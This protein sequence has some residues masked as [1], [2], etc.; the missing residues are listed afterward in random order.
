MLVQSC[1]TLCNPMNCSPPGSSVYGVSQARML[2]WVVTSYSR[3]ASQPTDP[4]RVSCI[5]RQVLYY[6]ATWEALANSTV[7]KL[8]RRKVNHNF[9]GKQSFMTP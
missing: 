3:G 2:E 8:V 6:S 5:G 1:L 7:K 9:A 4:T